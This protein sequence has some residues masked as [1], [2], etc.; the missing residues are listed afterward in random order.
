MMD[1]LDFLLLPTAPVPYYAAENPS[2]DDGD[3]FAPWS[4][5]VV[6]NLTQQTAATIP[7]GETASGLLAGLQIVG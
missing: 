4:N 3:I 2:L 1:G 5:T 7:C 6:V